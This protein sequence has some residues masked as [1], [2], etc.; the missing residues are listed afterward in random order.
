L[1][2]PAYRPAEE[3]QAL[4]RAV[5]P[6]RKNGVRLVAVPRKLCLRMFE[7]MTRLANKV[8]EVNNPAN[9]VLEVNNPANKVLEV[10]NP[11]KNLVKNLRVVSAVLKALKA[12]L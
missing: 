10:N 8:L 6:G 12:V 1:L 7:Q 11:V 9:K 2:P 3:R 4:K 5:E